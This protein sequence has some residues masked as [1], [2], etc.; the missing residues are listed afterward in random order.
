M[1]APLEAG[2]MV[3]R[4]AHAT[5]VQPRGPVNDRGR[6]MLSYPAPS[7]GDMTLHENPEIKKS[8]PYA[9]KS[10]GQADNGVA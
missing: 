1:W 10:L 4:I 3:E 5:L 9:P 2:P 7:A 6:V 8:T